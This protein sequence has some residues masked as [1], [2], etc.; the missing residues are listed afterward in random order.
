MK[1]GTTVSLAEIRRRAVA[2]QHYATRARSGTEAELVTALGCAACIQL[3]SISTVERSHRIALGARIGAYPEDA[4]SQLMRSGRIFEYWAHEACLLPAEDYPMHR[5][6]MA[7]YAS[8]H[9]W[10]G[11]VL[12]REP[13][14]TE[15][16]LAEIRERG[17][18]ASRSRAGSR[19]NACTTC[20]S[21]CF[22]SR[23]STAAPR[24]TTS[25]S[26]GRRCAA[27]RLGARSPRRRSPRCG[28]SPAG[29]RGCARTP[30]S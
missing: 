8:T 24:A 16:V 20:P 14:L 21:A 25:T 30:T 27:S 5:W 18:V 2:A 19:S 12:G 1:A 7:R 4:V 15:R 17:P 10:H 9:P 11:N 29:R 28:A 6:R 23:S 22:P 26:A 3:D 13:E